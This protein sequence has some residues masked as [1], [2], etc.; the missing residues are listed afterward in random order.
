MRKIERDNDGVTV[1]VQWPMVLVKDLMVVVE[2]E[3]LRQIMEGSMVVVLGR[4][5]CCM[6]YVTQRLLQGLRVNP[7]M[8]EISEGFVEKMTLIDKIAK[9]LS[10][11]GRTLA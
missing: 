10:G 6:S 8:C 2:E 9:M 3:G 7:I 4:R 5:G 11:D 1:R